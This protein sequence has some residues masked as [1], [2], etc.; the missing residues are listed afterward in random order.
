[1]FNRDL[2]FRTMRCE[3]TS[4]EI[5]LAT[6][7]RGLE[8]CAWPVFLCQPLLPV[9]YLFWPP[10]IVLGAVVLLDYMWVP[11]ANGYVSYPLA[12]V[13]CF[14]VRLKWPVMPAALAYYL[15]THQFYLAVLTAITPLIPRLLVQVVPK[16]N[17]I[18]VQRKMMKEIGFDP[19]QDDLNSTLD[20]LK[21]GLRSI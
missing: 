9:L 6:L 8:W 19:D 16:G 18:S 5:K 15:W 11:I 17:V 1:M 2:L 3:F 14:W 7:L 4:D 10:C 13:G 12:T 21:V 20:H